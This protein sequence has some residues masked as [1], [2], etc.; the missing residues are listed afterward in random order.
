M[1]HSMERVFKYRKRTPLGGLAADLTAES[2]RSSTPPAHGV[3]IY[4]KFWIIPPEGLHWADLAWLCFGASLSGESLSS[5]H[6]EGLCVKIHSLTFPLVDYRPEV[7]AVAM[8]GW[9]HDEFQLPE[10]GVR[11]DF[12]S[13]PCEYNFHWGGVTPF[14]NA[15]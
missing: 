14:S 3:Q 10:T 11:V 8:D 7:A 13:G 12:N 6:P 4:Y 15:Y 5:L 9:L 2:F 1:N